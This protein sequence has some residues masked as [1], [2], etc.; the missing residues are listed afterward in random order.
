MR[1]AL[2]LLGFHLITHDLSPMKK[3]KRTP[4]DWTWFDKGD[5][6]HA[7]RTC[8]DIL[9]A[10]VFNGLYPRVAQQAMLTL[11]LINLN[12]LLQKMDSVGHRYIAKNDIHP[13]CKAEDVTSL[14]NNARNA[15]CHLNS[16]NHFLEKSKVTYNV[17]LGYSPRALHINGVELGCDY[18]DDAAFIFGPNR[19]YMERHVVAAL[20]AARKFFALHV[21]GQ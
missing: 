6:D 4:A 21:S 15:S 12:D 8:S 17:V 7:I 5:I 19:V 3:A 10:G 18:A 16:G 14:I 1:T 11:L 2:T 13:A 20:H 9:Q